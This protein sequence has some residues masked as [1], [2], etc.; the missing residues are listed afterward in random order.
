MGFFIKTE[1]FTT[2]TI[3]LS[4]E[5]K[6]A[7]INKHKEWISELKDSGIEVISGY[8]VDKNRSPGGGGVLIIKASSYEEAI[9]IVTQ[10]PMIKSNL[11][12]WELHEWIQAK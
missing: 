11:V 12:T 2:K 3:E 8:L 1:K 10:D 4:K 7:Y 9:K 5:N 6:K